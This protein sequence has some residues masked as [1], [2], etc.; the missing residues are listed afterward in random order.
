MSS[1]SAVTLNNAYIHPSKGKR[2]A[3]RIQKN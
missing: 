2:H 3:F 1:I